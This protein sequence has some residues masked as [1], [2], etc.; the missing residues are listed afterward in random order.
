M[1]T[2]FY[3]F[4]LSLPVK[5]N[6]ENGIYLQGLQ[7]PVLMCLIQLFSENCVQ[8]CVWHIIMFRPIL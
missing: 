2:K 3:V 4:I 5:K 8:T 1:L 7:G 6:A